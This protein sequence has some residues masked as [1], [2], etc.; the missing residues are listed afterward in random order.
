MIVFSSEGAG[1]GSAGGVV[2]HPDKTNIAAKE[3][4]IIFFIDVFNSLKNSQGEQ[5]DQIG[6]I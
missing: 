4:I 2:L 3:S 5:D 6:L 1:K